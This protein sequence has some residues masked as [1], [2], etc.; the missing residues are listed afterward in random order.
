MRLGSLNQLFQKRSL[1]W[2]F[3]GDAEASQSR[4]P[5]NDRATVVFEAERRFSLGQHEDA[6]QRALVYFQHLVDIAVAKED[7]LAEL[8]VQ[9]RNQAFS[10]L[11]FFEQFYVV[12]QIDRLVHLRHHKVSDTKSSSELW[13]VFLQD[14]F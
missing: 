12:W 13:Y 8:V 14:L 4:G 10:Q 7:F 3:L 5:L 11:L 1:R 9:N 2:L 6:N